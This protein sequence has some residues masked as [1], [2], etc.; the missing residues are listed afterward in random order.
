MRHRY[1]YYSRTPVFSARFN[2]D[3]LPGPTCLNNLDGNVKSWRPNAVVANVI[4]NGASTLN[5]LAGLDSPA[6]ADV[7]LP[8]QLHLPEDAGDSTQD[9]HKGRSILTV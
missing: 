8:G 3:V 2:K 4:T 5:A 9:T 1:R 6:F 7:L